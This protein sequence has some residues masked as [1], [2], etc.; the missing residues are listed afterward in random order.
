MDALTPHELCELMWA[1]GL[2]E[3]AARPLPGL[4]IESSSFILNFAAQADAR[5]DLG[6]PAGRACA[7][8]L[9]GLVCLL[10]GMLLLA[11]HYAHA[12]SWREQPHA[13]S[14]PAEPPLLLPA[15]MRALRALYD[16]VIG[17]LC[18]QLDAQPPSELVASE[19]TEGGGLTGAPKAAL[20]ALGALHPQM[21]IDLLWS[22]GIRLGLGLG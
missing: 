1:V 6:G 15:R 4:K 12:M 22:A 5:L 14:G 3:A 19:A 20:G 13:G 7:V 2:H 17:L 21:L 16:S 11:P 10:H 18:A 8:G 9:D